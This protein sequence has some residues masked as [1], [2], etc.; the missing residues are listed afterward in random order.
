MADSR[1]APAPNLVLIGYRA[2]GKS[3]VGR[4]LADRLNRPFVDLDEVLVQEA[5]R[6]IVDIVAQGGWED[7]RRREKELAQ[8]FSRTGGKVLASGGG[9]VLDQENVQVLRESGI[10]IWL[11]ADPQVI[12]QR[13]G[14][15]AATQAFRPSLTGADALAEVE[16]V[17]AQREPLYRDAAHFVI[18]T[19]KL[20]I[21]EVVD[22]ILQA[23]AEY[24]LPNFV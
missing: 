5:G 19:T 16:E 1:S 6:A 13:L 18:D 22:R 14:L 7:F 4:D 11:K 23:I 2:T 10:L 20:S 21:P 3:S 8:R 24:G 12:R 15:D 9:V 17:L